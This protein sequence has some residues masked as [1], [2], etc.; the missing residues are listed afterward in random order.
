MGVG[1]CVLTVYLVFSYRVL[2]VERTGHPGLVVF[3]IVSG[4]LA[5]VGWFAVVGVVF[6]AGALLLQALERRK[7][8]LYPDAFMV[9]Q[10]VSI[11]SL[12]EC[13]SAKWTTLDSKRRLM[14]EI[15]L[16]AIYRA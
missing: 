15:E 10:L 2:R 12:V 16:V 5:I 9:T 7:S 11:L 6:T 14:R 4:I 1:L 3:L 8:S 13:G